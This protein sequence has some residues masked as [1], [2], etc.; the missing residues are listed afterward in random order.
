MPKIPRTVKIGPLI[1]AVVLAEV[2]KDEKT[3]ESLWGQI[4]YD[5]RTISLADGEKQT[6][7]VA[8]IHEA[9]HGLLEIC[10]IN[11]TEEQVQALAFVLYGFFRENSSLFPGWK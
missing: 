5:Q 8:L 11:M 10:G 1:Y 6:K 4:S 9:L 7:Y 3:Q 2:L